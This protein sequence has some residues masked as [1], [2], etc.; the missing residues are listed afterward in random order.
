[1]SCIVTLVGKTNLASV[2]A[3]FVSLVLRCSRAKMLAVHVGGPIGGVDCGCSC[4]GGE[5]REGVLVVV[6]DGDAHA[7]RIA[8]YMKIEAVSA[9]IAVNKLVVA[10]AGPVRVHADDDVVPCLLNAGG[11]SPWQLT[12]RQVGRVGNL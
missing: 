9:R 1:M 6:L 7:Q 5:E 11:V 3:G 4:G 12:C 8:G 2:V 10:D